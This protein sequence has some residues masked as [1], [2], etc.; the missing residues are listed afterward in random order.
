MAGHVHSHGDTPPHEHEGAMPGHTHDATPTAPTTGTAP[1]AAAPTTAAAVEVGPSPGGLTTRLL[2][3]IL[4]AAAMILGA[5]LEWLNEA[6]GTEITYRVFF[7]TDATAGESGL[8]ASAGFVLIVL[9]LLAL[10]GTAFRTG[11]LTRLAGALGLVAL[12][13]LVISTYG[14]DGT[15]G[16]LGPGFWLSALGSLLALI[17]GF[18]GSRPRVVATSV[19]A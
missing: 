8:I 11:W 1:V 13:L 2:L 3:T 17:G 4:G 9:G 19:R 12:V 15:V 7:S 6:S 5:F 10:L 16:N 18:F 14:A